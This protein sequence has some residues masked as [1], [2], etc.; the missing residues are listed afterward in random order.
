MAANALARIDARARQ[1][2]HLGLFLVGVETGSSRRGLWLVSA[3]LACLS[4]IGLV[5]GL[6]K[7]GAAFLP[8][9]GRPLLALL[10][11]LA[12][13]AVLRTGLRRI[14]RRVEQR[15]AATPPRVEG[16]PASC[17][18]CGAPLPAPSLGAGGIVAC[19]FCRAENLA[20]PATLE[21]MG[22]R[23]QQL[24][25]EVE[26]DL[27]AASRGVEP[28][29]KGALVL[30]GA[31]LPAVWLLGLLLFDP[32]W[33]L[34]RTLTTREQPVHAERYVLARLNDD[35]RCVARLEP[36]GAVSVPNPR[37]GFQGARSA[38]LDGLPSFEA[39]RLV[40][41]SVTCAEGGRSL[42]HGLV[43]RVYGG[44]EPRA[45]WAVVRQRARDLPQWLTG[46]VRCP[47]EHLSLGRTERLPSIPWPQAAK[48]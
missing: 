37:Y 27:R 48:P 21:R 20:D 14:G 8:V 35:V 16:E 31:A 29:A 18:L 3:V 33:R 34:A 32:G 40:G 24:L 38:A 28:W 46:D 10:A 6:A 17:R 1:L 30:G 36:G 4:A 15:F 42:V 41:E 22:R 7:H 26:V 23:A 9:W 39:E 47:L 13:L 44:A 25:D 12:F 5:A 43:L 11:T 19:A 2:G 45:N